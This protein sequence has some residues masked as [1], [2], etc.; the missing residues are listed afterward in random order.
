[1]GRR[2]NRMSVSRTLTSHAFHHGL[3]STS[4]SPA[5]ERRARTMDT[6]AAMR[7]L[8]SPEFLSPVRSMSSTYN[9]GSGDV[10][11]DEEAEEEQRDIA[12]RSSIQGAL[13]SGA[14]TSGA[15]QSALAG[16]GGDDAEA[17]SLA[18]TLQQLE[19]EPDNET[20]CASKY[21][22][23]AAY[24][25]LTEDSRAA[26]YQLWQ[27]SAPSFD[28]APATQRRIEADLKAIDSTSNLGV[29][30]DPRRWFVWSM[31]KQ[32]ARNQSQIESVLKGITSKLELLASQDACPICFEDFAADR[33]VATLSCAHKTCQ[34]CWS[35]WCQVA[36]GPAHA[37]CPLCRHS[38]FL[39]GLLQAASEAPELS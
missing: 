29:V 19:K 17:A 7:M 30:D 36:G 10:L 37:P 31:T 15:V 34:E 8:S 39:D 22:L 6:T 18:G 13:T 11:L 9:G 32:A 14:L 25:K 21:E 33:P 5:D 28:E 16:G 35:H 2:A 20:E 1:M 27:E 4:D 3:T 26:A 38:E 24:Q 12:L 23:F